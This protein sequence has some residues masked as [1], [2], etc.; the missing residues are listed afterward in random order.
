MRKLIL[1]L[2]PSFLTAVLAT[3]C[4]FSVFD[5]YEL[6]LHGRQLF[7]DQLSAYSV[8]FL[9]A[10]FFGAL[11]GLLLLQLH[12]PAREVNGFEAPPANPDAYPGE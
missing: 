2:W 12:K 6:A 8:F 9:L 4:F 5:P 7:H 11:N 3:S 1:I 10:W